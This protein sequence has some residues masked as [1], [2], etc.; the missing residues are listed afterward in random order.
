MAVQCVG[1]ALCQPWAGGGSPTCFVLL[2]RGLW[3]RVWFAR[4]LL[5]LRSGEGSEVVH[6]WDPW[7]KWAELNQL[8]PSTGAR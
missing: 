6:T 8:V 2:T 3:P 4:P 1:L 7:C 5:L